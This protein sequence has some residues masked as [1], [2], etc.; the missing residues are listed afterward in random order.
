MDNNIIL[1]VDPGT[2]L[3][4]YGIIKVEN[5]N[6][7]LLSMGTFNLKS[8]AIYEEKLKNIFIFLN[9]LIKQYKPKS[10]VFEDAFYATNAQVILKLGRIQGIIMAVSALNNIPTANYS[11][12]KIKLSIT[13]YGNANK[14]SVSIMLQKIFN[15]KENAS[16]LDSTD[17]LAVAVCHAM[18]REKNIFNKKSGSWKEFLAKNPDRILK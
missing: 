2:N 10:I 3:T 12:R 17:G 8:Y 9:D 14:N 6:L 1:G 13:G 18:Q 7:E 5:N 4:G 16:F 11:P 15:F